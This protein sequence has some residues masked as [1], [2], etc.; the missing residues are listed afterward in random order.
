MDSLSPFL[1]AMVMV[2][3]MRADMILVDD[4][5]I[6]SQREQVE[7]CASKKRNEGQSQQDMLACK[8][9]KC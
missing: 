9:K 6:C 4:T 7:I 5:V 1:F 8:K 3:Q 2:R